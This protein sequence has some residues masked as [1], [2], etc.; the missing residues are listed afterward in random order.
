MS[1]A[2]H[3]TDDV[4]P[5]SSHRAMNA[6]RRSPRRTASRGTF[7]SINA[8]ILVGGLLCLLLINTSLAQGAFEVSGLQRELQ[9]LQEEQTALA[10]GIAQRSSPI[11]LARAAS[12]L[13]MVRIRRA[14]FLRIDDGRIIGRPRPV[15]F[16]GDVRLSERGRPS[17]ANPEDGDARERPSS[18]AR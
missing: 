5:K 12:D 16:P 15:P 18:R 3:V 2:V 8:A 17:P 1:A 10:E 14:A 11:A 9:S 6:R 13:G 4:M 7:V